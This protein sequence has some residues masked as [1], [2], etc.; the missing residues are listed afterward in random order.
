MKSFIKAFKCLAVCL[1]LLMISSAV[2]EDEAVKVKDVKVSIIKDADEDGKVIEVSASCLD[3]GD[4]FSLKLTDQISKLSEEKTYIISGTID[5]DTQILTVTSVKE[6]KGKDHSG[7]AAE[8]EN[9]AEE[10]GNEE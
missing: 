9:A 2:A 5:A 6:F 7:A 8:G 10:K 1:S 4:Y 3:T